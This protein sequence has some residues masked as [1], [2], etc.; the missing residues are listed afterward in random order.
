MV[1]RDTF[2]EFFT[3]VKA[4]L[5]KSPKV[6][7]TLLSI[8]ANLNNAIVWMVSTS[9]LISNSSSDF[10]PSP[11]GLFRAHQLQLISPSPSCSI[12]FF[13]SLASS[14]YL[15]LFSLSFNFTLGSAGTAKSTIWQVRLFF[16]FFVFLLSLDLFVWPIFS[17]PFV[18]QNPR[19]ISESHFLSDSE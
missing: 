7:G 10:L 14:K 4:S 11:W 16:C 15:S 19:E 12:V 2:L 1:S 3:L 9:P 13:N 18:S 8:L 6:S 17:D 5:L